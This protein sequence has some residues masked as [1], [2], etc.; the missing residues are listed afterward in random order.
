M[1]KLYWEVL[2]KQLHSSTH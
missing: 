2:S 1:E